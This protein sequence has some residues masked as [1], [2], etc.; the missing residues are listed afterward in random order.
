MQLRLADRKALLAAVTALRSLTPTRHQTTSLLRDISL[1][2]PTS[3]SQTPGPTP[4][5]T[6]APLASPPGY[7]PRLASPSPQ[8]A[9]GRSSVSREHG[10][11]FDG[12]APIT[13]TNGPPPPT[14]NF[15]NGA[16]S[17]V[18][19]PR[20]VPGCTVTEL[21]LATDRDAWYV[22]DT[23]GIDRA[24]ASGAPTLAVRRLWRIDNP[25]LE[26]RCQRWLAELKEM[27]RLGMRD[28]EHLSELA[29][30]HGCPP[31]L[32][33]S[34]CRSGLLRAGHP[35]N[36]SPAVDGG[37]NGHPYH[38]VNVACYPDAI[39]DYTHRP[40]Q[41]LAPGQRCR[42]LRVCVVPGRMRQLSSTD[43][44]ALL[45]TAGFDSHLAPDLQ[46]WFLFHERQC[47][48]THVLEVEAL[49]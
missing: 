12:D 49:A 21:D 40:P 31:S 28:N 43:G 33:D 30:Y 4:V 3:S 27:I 46:G 24:A 45:P 6:S 48:P 38:G 17:L 39:L 44:P 5:G 13:S 20:S 7:S 29:G 37:A 2:R 41:P 11:S 18:T 26:Q 22:L 8:K 9:D 10:A 23:C 14:H 35:D 32:L 1:S 15:T 47:Y 36:P 25:T 19:S 16:L 34:V 42:I